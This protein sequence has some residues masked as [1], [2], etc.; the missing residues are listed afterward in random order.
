MED[1]AAALGGACQIE[2]SPDAGTIV[3]ATLPIV[4]DGQSSGYLNG[5]KEAAAGRVA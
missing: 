1:Y 2:S 5:S 3:H 4:A